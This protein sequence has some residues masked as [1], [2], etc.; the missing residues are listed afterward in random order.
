MMMSAEQYAEALAMP[1][2][3]L[4]VTAHR[5]PASMQRC[6]SWSG[7]ARRRAAGWTMYAS[8][9]TACCRNL[10][11][12]RAPSRRRSAP[13]SSTPRAGEIGKSVSSRYGPP[14]ASTSARWTRWPACASALTT[15]QGH[16]RW[17]WALEGAGTGLQGRA[18]GYDAAAE[19][20]LQQRRKTA[21]A[22]DRR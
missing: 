7:G 15:N 21:K 3:H 4:P 6:A 20:L 5:W 16:H 1:R 2:K 14:H 11:S 13:S 9:W 8:R 19:K 17:R 12:R 18:R 10:G 22:L